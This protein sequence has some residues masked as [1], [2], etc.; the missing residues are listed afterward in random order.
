VAENQKAT[1]VSP[2][3]SLRVCDEFSSLREWSRTSGVGAAADELG[4]TEEPGADHF[5][6]ITG[7]RDGNPIQTGPARRFLVSHLPHDVFPGG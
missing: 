7:A 4:V 1:W 6:R 5:R 2:G 3:G